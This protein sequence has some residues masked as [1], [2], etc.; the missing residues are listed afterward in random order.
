MQNVSLYLGNDRLDLFGDEQINVTE[1]IRNAKD[2]S[3]VFT[4]FSRQFTIPAS[5]NNNK[6]FQHYY[7]YHI[8]NG[9]DARVRQTSRIEINH[10]VFRYG[11]LKLNGVDLK[12][13]SHLP[14]ELP[15]MV[16]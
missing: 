13:G 6:L 14:I 9:Y 8:Q 10:L 5:K 12:D 4:T 15:S 7:N 11:K 3:K 2:I 16:A 1:S